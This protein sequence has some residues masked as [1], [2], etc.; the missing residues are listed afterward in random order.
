MTPA[1]LIAERDALLGIAQEPSP[2]ELMAAHPRYSPAYER[3]RKCAANR[4]S[5]GWSREAAETMPI[6]QKRGPKGR[7]ERR[8]ETT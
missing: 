8:G 4:V 5:D 2:R 6:G 3:G 7:N 1:D